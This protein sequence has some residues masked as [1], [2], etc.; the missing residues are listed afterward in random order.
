M[1]LP[2]RFSLANTPWGRALGKRRE[3][4]VNEHIAHS[5]KEFRPLLPGAL[6]NEAFRLVRQYQ[7]YRR[8]RLDW[9]LILVFLMIPLV[10][11]GLVFPFEWCVEFIFKTLQPETQR[12]ISSALG[13][14]TLMLL[15]LLFQKFVHYREQ[16]HFR[17][18]LADLHLDRDAR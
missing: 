16:V 15:V 18:F 13:I 14:C 12:T 8:K 5:L 10:C 7:A 2:P 3:R 11:G 9:L 17:A 1:H 6:E 4:I